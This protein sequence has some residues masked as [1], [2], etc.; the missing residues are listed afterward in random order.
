M[1]VLTLADAQQRDADDPFEP[2]R[3]LFDLPAGTIYLDGNSLGAL[4]RATPAAVAD[5]V[6]RQWGGDLIASWNVHD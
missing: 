3:A 2:K 6:A 5:V 4:P 1:T